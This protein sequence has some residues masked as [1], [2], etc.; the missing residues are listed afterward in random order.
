MGY[1]RY[2]PDICLEGLSK[3]NEKCSQ[4]SQHP[5]WIQTGHIL[6]TSKKHY[7]LNQLAQIHV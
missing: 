6:N 5:G 4:N 1:L 2:Y 3:N 7:N